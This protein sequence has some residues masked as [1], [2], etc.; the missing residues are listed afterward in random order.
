MWAVEIDGTLCGWARVTVTAGEGRLR[1]EVARRLAGAEA[2]VLLTQLQTRLRA[3]QQVTVLTAAAPVPF[4]PTAWSEAGFEEAG[5]A[6]R[7][8]RL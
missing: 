5:G 7:W 8:V 2:V 6:A 4:P 3:D 1:I